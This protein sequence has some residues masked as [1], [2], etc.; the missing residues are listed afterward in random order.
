MKKN[1]KQLSF[2]KKIRF[3]Y[4]LSVLNENTLEEV[5]TFRLSR[6]SVFW[7]SLSFAL[8][9]VTLTSIVIINTPIRNYL[10]GY[11]DSEVRKTMVENTLKADSL[12]QVLIIQSNYLNN[13]HSILQGNSLVTPI[14]QTDSV[15]KNAEVN[16]NKP[17]TTV[18]FV[19]TYEEEEKYKLNKNTLSQELPDNLIF[20]KPVKGIVS[21]HFDLRTKHYGIDIAANP[22]ESVLATMKGTIVFT[23]FD[24]NAGYVIQIQ[25]SNGFVS[26][27]KHNA[28]LLKSQGAEVNAGEA[29]ALA[30]NTGNLSSGTH[31]HFELWLKGN[32]VNPEE[33][34]VF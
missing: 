20:Y 16:L 22:T 32:P 11:L 7:I 31:L 25:H 2:W 34:I 23:G 3:K 18:N 29:I 1:P 24:A 28:S 10:P 12:E 4:K 13:I 6:L 8:L 5:F 33:F 30:G 14:T 26:I 17:E 19:R 15:A 9:L 27:Y 21:D